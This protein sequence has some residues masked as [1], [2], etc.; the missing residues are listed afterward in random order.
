ML[1][2]RGSWSFATWY[3]TFFKKSCSY[4]IAA[5]LS[6]PFNY[7][8]TTNSLNFS[9]S[10]S[11]VSSFLKTAMK[12]YSVTVSSLPERPSAIVKNYLLTSKPSKASGFTI[13][14][15][16]TSPNECSSTVLKNSFAKIKL[17][18]LSTI[19]QSLLAWLRIHF[20]RFLSATNYCFVYPSSFWSYCTGISAFRYSVLAS[21][22]WTIASSVGACFMCILFEKSWI[23][24]LFCFLT[25]ES[26][27][28]YF[29]SSSSPMMCSARCTWLF[30]VPKSVGLVNTNLL[31]SLLMFSGLAWNSLT[32]TT[33]GF[34]FCLIHSMCCLLQ[35]IAGVFSRSVLRIYWILSLW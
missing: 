32:V 6:W 15:S 33:L 7:F 13:W 9:V 25:L 26:D 27:F 21:L 1:S 16:V 34:A 19:R 31:N 4:L 14:S 18:M 17:L 12:F 29:L 30:W 22:S 3:Q 8:A 11:L 28:V 35:F 5:L 2:S 24:F 23:L 10:L 20:W